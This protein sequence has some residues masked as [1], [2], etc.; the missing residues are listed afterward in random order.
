M[1]SLNILK[2]LSQNIFVMFLE[3]VT[4]EHSGNLTKTSHW[5]HYKNILVTFSERLWNN[6]LLAGMEPVLL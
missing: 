5:K 4:L 2:R 1:L 3:N 6:K